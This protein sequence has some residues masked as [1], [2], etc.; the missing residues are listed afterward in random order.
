MSMSI[1]KIIEMMKSCPE[2]MSKDGLKYLLIR[3][4][5]VAHQLEKLEMEKHLKN[6]NDAITLQAALLWLIS[7]E[8]A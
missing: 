5:G 6:N 1:E 4:L 3:A 2:P 7:R 8:A